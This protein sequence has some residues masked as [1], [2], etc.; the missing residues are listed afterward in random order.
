MSNQITAKII[1]DSISQSGIRLTTIET[2]A[3]KFIDAEFEKHRM[4]SSNSSSSRAIPFGPLKEMY[5]PEDI[6][7]KQKGMQ[8]Y[9]QIEIRDR[10]RFKFDIESYYDDLQVMLHEYENII[11][12][13][14]LN[15]YLEPWMLQKKI[16]TATEWDNFFKLRLAKDAQPEIQELARCMKEAMDESTPEVLKPGEYHLPY[17]NIFEELNVNNVGI[18]NAIKCSIARCA[19]VSYNN[20][21]GSQPDINKD[22]ELY[23][24]L[25]SSG[26]MSP[27]EHCLTPMK[28]S[29]LTESRLKAG[30]DWERGTTHLD[31]DGRYWSGN[32]RGWL[33]WRQIIEQ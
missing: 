9:E 16:V 17:I 2:Q 6:R 11:H 5:T 20:H 26:H 31:R 24:F 28:E 3:P 27:F 1:A 10:G 13:Q 23:N 21:D 32:A 25:L 15:R 7:K 14:H 30:K 12:K 22:I 8:G 19:R 4:L 18:E 29:H 33:Q